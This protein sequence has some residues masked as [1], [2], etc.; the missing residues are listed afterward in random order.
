MNPTLEQL[1][2]LFADF[3]KKFEV[4][5]EEVE[6]N[7]NYIEEPI[8][9]EEAMKFINLDNTQTIYRMVRAGRIPYYKKGNRLYFFKS[10]LNEWIKTKNL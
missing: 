5:R 3:V 9:V 4:F 6:K 1:P 10:E 2:Q 7:K 8:G